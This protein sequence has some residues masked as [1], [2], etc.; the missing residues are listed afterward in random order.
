MHLTPER[1]RRSAIHAGV[2]AALLE[3][4]AEARLRALERGA[5]ALF[6]AAE[7]GDAE[8]C[9]L[10]YRAGADATVVCGPTPGAAKP[11]ASSATRAAAEGHDHLASVLDRAERGEPDRA[12]AVEIDR[13]VAVPL[14]GLAD[15]PLEV[16][17]GRD[18]GWGRVAVAVSDAPVGRADP[19]VVTGYHGEAL[20]RVPLRWRRADATGRRDVVVNELNTDEQV[21][22]AVL[23]V[24]PPDARVRLELE[25]RPHM[26]I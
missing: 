4:E 2:A 3:A 8:L 1:R 16:V 26:G 17:L 6:L 11:W 10:L 15:P 13:L 22:G 24:G 19:G 25:L 20:F 23:E 12:I 18:A 21:V 5:T 14:G 7:A 9:E